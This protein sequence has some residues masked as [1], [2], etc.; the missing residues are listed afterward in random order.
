MAKKGAMVQAGEG[1][2]QAS[3]N[4]HGFPSTWALYSHVPSTPFCGP[5]V[6]CVSGGD[7]TQRKR[8]QVLPRQFLGKWA[9]CG[10]PFGSQGCFL[11]QFSHL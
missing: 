4:R 6:S 3:Q 9:L 11:P 1:P 7:L 2:E 8:N 5:V 10:E